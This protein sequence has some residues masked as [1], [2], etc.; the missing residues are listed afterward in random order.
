MSKNPYEILGIPQNASREE[1]DQAYYTL[2]D[3][4]RLD[5]H[6]EGEKGKQAA[7]ALDAVE[8]AYRDI[9]LGFSESNQPNP[10]NT[11]ND[12]YYQESAVS[13]EPVVQDNQTFAVVEKFIRGKNYGDAQKALDNISERS[14]EWHFYQSAIYYKQGWINES[15]SQLELAYSME[16]NNPKYRDSLNK[17]NQ[18]LNSKPNVAQN[19]NGNNDGYNRSYSQSNY[20]AS[21]TEDSCCRA[22]QAA[23]CINCLCDCCCRG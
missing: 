10:A 13:S 18:K 12:S 1:V 21:R 16:P 22:C 15:K 17:L 8:I 14:A 11:Y 19:Y 23:I 20:D 4:Y 5:M 7:K 9:L 3:K 2:R 6:S